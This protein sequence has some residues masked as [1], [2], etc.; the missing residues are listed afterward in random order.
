MTVNNILLIYVEHTKNLDAFGIH[1]K[2]TYHKNAALINEDVSK[3]VLVDDGVF[4]TQDVIHN[5][6]AMPVTRHTTRYTC[7]TAV[8]FNA[9]IG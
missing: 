8:I 5:D 4:H 2:A 9:N 7:Y 1:G 3:H 6:A